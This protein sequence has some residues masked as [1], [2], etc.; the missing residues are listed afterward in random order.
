MKQIKITYEDVPVGALEES[1]AQTSNKQ[2]FS[3]LS[4]LKQDINFDKL[5]NPCELNQTILDNSQVD[6]N[7]LDSKFAWWSQSLSDD[8]GIFINHP[9]LQITFENLYTSPGI[10]FTFDNNNNVFCSDLTVS[11]YRNT[12]LIASG[13]F[14]PDMPVFFCEKKAQYYNKIIVEFKKMNMPYSFLKL[15]R[16]DFGA[17]REFTNS[18]LKTVKI[19]EEISLIS[20]ELSINTLDFTIDSS[21]NTEYIF[22]KKQKTKITFDNQTIGV[23][24]IDASQRHSKNIW[25]VSAYDYIGLLDKMT[26]NGGI[27]K[28]KNAFALANEILDDIPF[29]MDTNLRTKTVSGWLNIDTIRNSLLNLAF[30]IGAVVTT[31]RNNKI[32]I[33]ELSNDIKQIY[34]DSDIYVGDKFE[35]RDKATQIQ[36]TLHNYTAISETVELY[37]GDA[38]QNLVIQFSEPIHDLSITNGQIISS[39]ANFALINANDE[40]VLSGQRYCDSQKVI[41][42]KNELITPSDPQN[43]ITF[44]DCTLINDTNAQQ[45]AQKIFD[46]YKS[47]TFSDI[48]LKIKDSTVGDKI[49]FAT[50]FMGE[51]SGMIESLNYSVNGNEIIAQ[52]S[53]KIDE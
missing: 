42:L 48:K 47:M 46:Y 35:R 15:Q 7:F 24:F 20:N 5:S 34:T 18:E 40:C 26:F 11:W 1:I 36:L 39:N 17:I 9:V 22:Q 8:T 14:T 45:I 12:T 50:S 41:S 38:G 13:D 33:K 25:V 19:Q 44:S 16:V 49:T 52:A 23:F 43:I 37:K 32:I 28:N 27:Y 3:D 53:V 31:A 21:K 4:L 29:E 6:I 10:T 51:Q 2:T 30:A